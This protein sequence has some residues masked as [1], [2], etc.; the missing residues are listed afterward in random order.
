MFCS[1]GLLLATSVRFQQHSTVLFE[2]TLGI[3]TWPLGI[4]TM[5][6][7]LCVSCVYL[8]FFFLKEVDEQRYYSVLPF[9]VLF[10]YRLFNEY[11]TC[12]TESVLIKYICSVSLAK[13]EFVNKEYSNSTF[14][15]SYYCL[16]LVNKLIH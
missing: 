8:L 15:H 9:I 6:V 14:V 3:F 2:L 1:S 16:L 13:P 10:E 11:L 12:A 4:S 7:Y 5:Y